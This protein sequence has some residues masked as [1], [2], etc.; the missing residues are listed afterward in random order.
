M[1]EETENVTVDY[2]QNIFTS[3]RENNESL[4]Q[5]LATIDPLITDAMNSKLIHPFEADDVWV[6]I[7]SM[8]P[9]QKSRANLPYFINRTE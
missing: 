1:D 5:V 8:G 4:E 3:V 6:A 2:S 7:Q 9:K